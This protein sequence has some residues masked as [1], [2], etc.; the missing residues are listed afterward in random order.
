MIDLARLRVGMR[1]RRPIENLA[2]DIDE[3]N[4]VSWDA[5]NVVVGVDLLIR[6]GFGTEQTAANATIAR[7][8]LMEVYPR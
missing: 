8:D 5:T 3:G 7:K 4:V 2:A 1:V 6:G